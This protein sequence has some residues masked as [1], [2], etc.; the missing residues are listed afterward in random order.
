M[1]QETW[2]MYG[3]SYMTNVMSQGTWQMYESFRKSGRIVAVTLCLSSFYDIVFVIDEYV[4]RV[5]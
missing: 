3:S 2:Q 4:C 1:G 5:S